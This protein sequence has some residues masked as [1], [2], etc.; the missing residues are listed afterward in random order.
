[1]V[2]WEWGD[3][4]ENHSQ[5]TTQ[6]LLCKHFILCNNFI[7]LQVT[8]CKTLLSLSVNIKMQS[9][10]YICALSNYLATCSAIGMHT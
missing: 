2:L 4:F 8:K 6:T 7:A 5:P 10:F 1:M 3:N 9:Y